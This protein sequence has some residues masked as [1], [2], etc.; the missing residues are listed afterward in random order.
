MTPDLELWIDDD[1][2][3]CDDAGTGAT[4][5]LPLCSLVEAYTRVAYRKSA[6]FHLAPGSYD[7]ADRSA[8]CLDRHIAV[9]G[10]GSETVI[11]DGPADEPPLALCD[12]A[13]YLHDMLLHA[14]VGAALTCGAGAL[15]WID[16][17]I[18]ES[19]TPGILAEGCKVTVTRSHLRENETH[20]IEL[21][22]DSKL[23]MSSSIV[24]G[25]TQEGAPTGAVLVDSSVVDIS[26]STFAGNQGFDLACSGASGGT[27]SDSLLVS[28]QVA[29]SCP[30]LE[31][32][33]SVIETTNVD[34]EANAALP[35]DAAWFV[36]AAGGDFRLSGASDELSSVGRRDLGDPRLDFEGDAWP[37]VPGAQMYPGA[38][39]P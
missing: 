35:Y 27:V 21:R 12:D 34:G 8:S 18:I 31:L 19:G 39:Q 13:V 2:A 30:S 1:V 4:A 11:H 6:I 24:A 3:I 14:N 37:D 28:R 38:D 29:V 36:D 9:L 17:S 32:D 26:S 23:T 15:L 20:A 16:A 10:S 5:E 22:A 33:H 25:T 7:G